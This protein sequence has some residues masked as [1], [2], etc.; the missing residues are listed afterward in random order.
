MCEWLINLEHSL[1]DEEAMKIHSLTKKGLGSTLCLLSCL[2][3]VFVLDFFGY[4]FCLFE[5]APA[6]KD[7]QGY[8]CHIKLQPI[9]QFYYLQ[10]ANTTDQTTVMTKNTV[11]SVS[12]VHDII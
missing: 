2:H 9:K 4:L 1:A 3:S 10:S 5:F 8:E 12:T 7:A 6:D 11:F